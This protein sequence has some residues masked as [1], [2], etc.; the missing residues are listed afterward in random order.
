MIEAEKIISKIIK[1]LEMF[2]CKTLAK[3]IV[4]MVLISVGVADERVTEL[5]GGCNKSA[6]VLKKS[7]K[8]GEEDKLFMVGGGGRKQKRQDVESAVIE[9][10]EKNDYHTRQQI[11]DMILEKFGIKVSVITV[12][13]ILKKTELSG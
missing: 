3:R 5:T 13:K 7:M 10:I 4:S 6:R 1:F 9:E 11:A 12:K 8:N 2:M